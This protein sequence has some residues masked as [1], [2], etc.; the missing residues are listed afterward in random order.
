MEAKPR[1][2]RANGHGPHLAAH[3]HTS[4]NSAGATSAPAKQK[5]YITWQEHVYY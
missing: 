4:N 1:E 2:P 5:G 3:E